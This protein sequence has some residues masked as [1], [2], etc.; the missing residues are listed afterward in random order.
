MSGGCICYYLIFLCKS[1]VQCDGKVSVKCKMSS[2]SQLYV[3]F[4]GVVGCCE[5]KCK[6]IFMIVYNREGG[7]QVSGGCTGEL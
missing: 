2:E 6:F 4:M 5:V 3:M 7:W 1:S